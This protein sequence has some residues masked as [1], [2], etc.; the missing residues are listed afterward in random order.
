MSWFD[1]DDTDESCSSERGKQMV[2]PDP[3]SSRGDDEDEVLDSLDAFMAGIESSAAV[4][5][6]QTE[7]KQH[8]ETIRNDDDAS[9]SKSARL[10]LYNADEATAHWVAPTTKNS[11]D[12]EDATKDIATKRD[13][14]LPLANIDHS[15][16]TYEPFRKCFLQQSN[17][18]W[19]NYSSTT[20]STSVDNSEQVN[21]TVTLLQDGINS[22]RNGNHLVVQPI[23]S[24]QDLYERSDK[25][26]ILLDLFQVLTKGGFHLPTP[27]QRYAMPILLSGYDILCTA[28]TGSG[29]TLSYALPLVVHVC[30]QRPIVPTIDG[31]IGIIVSPTRELATQTTKVVQSLISPLMGKVICVT[32]GNRGTYELSKELKLQGCEIVCGTPGRIIDMVQ[33]KNGGIPNLHRV[34]MV[35]VDEADKL[36]SMGFESQVTSLLRNIR[37][38]AQ[39]CFVSATFPNRMRRLL[40]DRWA[41]TN[42]SSPC[43]HISVGTTGASSEHVLQHAIILPNVDAKRDWLVSYVTTL[44][45]NNNNGRNKNKLIVFVSSRV[46]CEAVAQM[47]RTHT[48]IKDIKEIRIGSIHGDKHQLHRNETLADFRKGKLNILVATDVAARGLDVKDVTTVVNYNVANTMDSHVHRIGRAG[49]MGG[50]VLREDS[51]CNGE[52]NKSTS[53]HAQG[54]AYTLLTRDDADFANSL[55]GAFRREGRPVSAELIELAQKSKYNNN[56]NNNTTNNMRHFHTKRRRTS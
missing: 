34:T 25:N 28:S 52:L 32:G 55:L 14:I 41:S 18:T 36:L 6:K 21:V 48:T 50:T 23:D 12:N 30:D 13:T 49:R 5:A 43:V 11:D 26:T 19:N 38:D 56:S 3:T 45:L 24:F 44:F 8:A 35:V 37:P 53:H 39:R 29:K 54:E 27:I 20:T 47:L 42:T 4:D 40:T 1:E 31:P 46:D 33:Y 17:K 15:T 9:K 10:D 7:M 51:C 22:T 2:V 16:I